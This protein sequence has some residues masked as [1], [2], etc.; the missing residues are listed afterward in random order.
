MAVTNIDPGNPPKISTNEKIKP[1]MIMSD[2]VFNY[3][4]DFWGIYNTIA[5]ETT[6]Q[7]ALKKIEKSIQE[8]SE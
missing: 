2:Q 6:L 4:S 8:I 3:D 1:N 5:P 7:E